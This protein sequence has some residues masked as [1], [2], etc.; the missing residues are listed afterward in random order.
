MYKIIVILLSCFSFMTLNAQELKKHRWEHRIVII[1]TT[2]V[3]SKIYQEQQKEFNNTSQELAERRLVVYTIEGDTFSFINPKN[4]TQNTS[5]K[6]TG[7]LKRILNADATFEIILIGL[8]GGI[9]LQ[10]INVLT[11]K[12]LFRI[13]DS[14]PMRRNEMRRKK[15]EN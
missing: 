6:L 8:D 10:Q 2:D 7:K 14:M 9:K 13:I 15:G 1:K 4:T 3:D 11:K 5:G 12:E